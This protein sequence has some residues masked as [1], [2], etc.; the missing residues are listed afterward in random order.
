MIIKKYIAKSVEDAK[1][2]ISK[3][4][5][6]HADILTIQ[7]KKTTGLKALFS[8]QKVEVTAAI[9][10]EDL[11]AH[12]GS[13]LGTSQAKP[14]NQ[15][16]YQNNLKELQKSLTKTAEPGSASGSRR[17]GVQPRNNQVD[18]RMRRYAE[19]K[20]PSQKVEVQESDRDFEPS[21]LL[22]ELKKETLVQRT[23][24]TRNDFLRASRGL[25]ETFKEE[26]KQT[27]ST[28]QGTKKRTLE[29]LKRQ[30]LL[31]GK[32]SSAAQGRNKQTLE[33]LKKQSLSGEEGKAA[34][35]SGPS[36][37][38]IRN[39]IREE[40]QN[41]GKSV[42]EAPEAEIK[43]I[44][45][46][47]FLI[48]KGVLPSIAYE[49]EQTLKKQFG[50]IDLNEK[51]DKKT[52]WINALRRELA[53]RIETAGP[54]LLQ[55]SK[56]AIYAIIGPTGV[57]K[58]TTLIKIATEYSGNLG[59]RV[60]IISLDQKVGAQDQI[61]KLTSQYQIP[62]A[63]ATTG[64]ELRSAV[65]AFSDRHL[66]LIDTGGRSQYKWEEIDK[67]SEV[68]SCV[69]EVHA[70]LALSATTKDVDMIGTVQ[71][72]SRIGIDSLVLTKMDETI[73]YGVLLNLCCKTK[74]KIRYL[75]NGQTIPSDL[76]IA[77]P[78]AISRQMLVMHNSRSF[79]HL[80][81]MATA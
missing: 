33:D 64:Y 57:G 43:P 28:S 48:Q 80:R 8:S 22:Q 81:K 40:I 19:A 45:S 30:S 79:N 10:E 63:L 68:L 72:F 26:E 65:D 36:A 23:P 70:L 59:K 7:T 2:A 17:G 47:G 25:L 52:Q 50:N 38:E 56:P 32:A 24:D 67:L 29:D 74:M 27:S 20:T 39:I 54:I 34:K 58:T 14:R 41:A 73:A 44:G 21:L 3:E 42:Q 76:S 11:K 71:E 46:T 9:S 1:K 66:I 35:G 61:K 13:S 15:G 5:G 37:N 51:S 77:D 49:I 12:T 6:P 53:R 62:L 16:K 78:N 60:G 4:L 55:A 75:T 18:P 69:D 31:E